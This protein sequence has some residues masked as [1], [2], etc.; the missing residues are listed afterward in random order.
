MRIRKIGMIIIKR[1]IERE[2]PIKV[3]RVASCPLP[4]KRK[5]CPG[6]TPRAV[7][8]SG[9]PRKIEGMKLRKVWVIAIEVMKTI[10]VMGVRIVKRRA[11]DEIRKTARRFV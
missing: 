11:D 7:S 9:A 5:R 6:I 10:K 1:I 3:R 4:F 2:E 8:S